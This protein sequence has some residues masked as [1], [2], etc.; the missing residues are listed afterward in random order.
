MAE[1]FEKHSERFRGPSDAIDME[2]LE[3]ETQKLL[4]LG[5]MVAVS[6]HAALGS[7]FIFKKTEVRVVRPPTMELVIRRP[8]MTKPFEFKKK[9]IK[10]REYKKKEIVE[11]R[12]TAEI[13]TKEAATTLMG[14]VASYDFGKMEIETGADL[15][16]T[17]SIDIEMTATRLA[18]F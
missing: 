10:Q 3:K 1:G 13:K 15:I 17:E 12:P 4:F 14:S 6:F 2:K 9:R 16:I 18:D 11:R 7:Y 8:R 5:L